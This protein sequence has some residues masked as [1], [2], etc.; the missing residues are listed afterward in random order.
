MK[1]LKHL[2]L[3]SRISINAFA[4]M[5]LMLW[6]GLYQM[7]IYADDCLLDT[8]SDGNADTNVDTD[9]GANSNGVNARVACGNGAMATGAFGTAVGGDS[10]ATATDAAALGNSANATG[11][12]STALGTD[13]EASGTR[14]IAIG[15]N[16]EATATGAIAIGANVT[17]S[18]AETMTV[19]VPIE[20]IRND[21][22]TQIK[23]NE[24]TAGNAVQTLFNVICDTWD[25]YLGK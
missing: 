13:T 7:P 9:L 2:N 25:I 11:I 10:S 12:S 14:S 20:V 8:N 4:I 16:A 1:S 5:V 17:A 18:K 21:G 22:T 23:V 6:L 3:K 15:D 24:K 19:G